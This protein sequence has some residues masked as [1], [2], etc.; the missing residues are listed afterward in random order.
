ML[1]IQTNT[2]VLTMKNLRDIL[3][4][5]LD[6]EGTLSKGDDMNKQYLKA[7]KA[8]DKLT[9]SKKFIQSGAYYSVKIKSSELASFIAEGNSAYEYFKDKYDINEVA[10]I[11]DV[12][13]TREHN[14]SL[15]CHAQVNIN[16]NKGTKFPLTIVASHLLFCT[17]ED[18][19]KGV[20]KGYEHEKNKGDVIAIKLLSLFKDKYKTIVDLRNAFH[21]HIRYTAKY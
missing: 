18:K 2:K 17:S 20:L 19:A 1:D 13:S 5:I 8:Y 12:L 3:E 9:K 7:E 10:I 6:I 21:E 15:N 11:V 16:V 14:N 4:G